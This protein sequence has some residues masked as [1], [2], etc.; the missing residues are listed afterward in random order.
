[1]TALRLVSPRFLVSIAAATAVTACGGKD[2]T[3]PA[4]PTPSSLAVV[5]GDNQTG[6]VGEALTQPLVVKVTDRAGTALS[7]VTVAW[8]VPLGA[9][10]VSAASTPSDAQG[11]AQVTWTLGPAAGPSTNDLTAT[12]TGLPSVTFTASAIA[13]PPTRLTMVAGNAQTGLVGQ[14]LPE[15]LIV[16]VRD[17]FGNAPTSLTVSWAVTAGGG[18]VSAATVATDGAGE[19]MMTWTLGPAEGADNNSVQ[20]S[21]LGLAGSPITFTASGATTVVYMD[22]AAFQQVTAGRGTPSLVNFDDI[23]ASPVTNTVAGRTPFDGNH[24][25]SQG[26]TFASPGG[27]PLFIAP[28]GLFWNASNSLSVGGFPYQSD[29]AQHAA[30]DADS[31]RVTLNPGCAA[32]SLQLLD[33][34]IGTNGHASSADSI[35]FLDSNGA[36]VQRIPFPANY[37]NYRAFAGLV[38]T[39][40]VVTTILVAEQAHNGDDVDYDDFTCFPP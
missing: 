11:E 36:V 28:G 15:P 18:S 25:A 6:V 31:L 19:A 7:G 38:S 33:I 34:G 9:G 2:G 17:Q 10:R 27:Y 24:Y 30:D 16:A 20:A 12:V 29:T 3:A 32:V 39:S 37:T 35:L 22:P 26:F 4:G 40:H 5:A 8:L 1:M 14:P 13:G 23:D 21:T